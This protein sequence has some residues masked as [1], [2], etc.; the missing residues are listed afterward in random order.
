MPRPVTQWPA[1]YQSRLIWWWITV[2][3]RHEE[4]TGLFGGHYM[5]ILPTAE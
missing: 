1:W 5:A 2:E 3:R 4:H